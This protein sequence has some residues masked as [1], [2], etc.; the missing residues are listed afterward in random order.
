MGAR[1]RLLIAAVTGLAASAVILTSGRL[2]LA[3][4]VLI[5]LG[6]VAGTL[7][8]MAL[9]GP[10]RGGIVA[11]ILMATLNRYPAELGASIKPEH[12]AAPLVGLALLPQAREL[13]GRLSRVDWLFLAWIGWSVI[14]GLVHAPDRADSTQLWAMLLLVAFPYF[15]IV[16]TTRTAGRLNFLLGAWFAIGLVSGLFGLATHLLYAAGVNLGIQ[17]NPVTADPTVPGPFRESNLFGSAMMMLTLT[18]F[19]LLILAPRWRKLAAVVAPVGFLALQVS[20]TR[21]AWIAFV[22]GG[23][24][25]AGGLAY[26]SGRTPFRFDQRALRPAALVGLAAV[27]GTLVIW[28]PLGGQG[29]PD[30]E[31]AARQATARA[32]VMAT[33]NATPTMPSLLQGTPTP[34]QVVTPT[35]APPDIVGR[36]SS[37]SDVS[38][39]SLR[40]RLEFAEQA[41]RD[42]RDQPILGK[43]IGSFGQTYTTTSYDRAWLSNIFVRVLHDGGVVGFA[44]FLLPLLLL[45]VDGLRLLDRCPEGP[46]RVALALGLAVLGMFVAFQATEGFQLAWYW[47]SLGLFAAALRLANGRRERLGG[48]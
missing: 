48:A 28:V 20:F 8:L 45:A 18:A 37:I 12:F 9:L 24:A 34:F 6:S 21:T 35:P 30:H 7:A 47:A 16:T 38:D 11:L 43:G 22:A 31:E 25:L 2:E 10:A 33:P 17:I 44:L 23:L 1:R 40:I 42:W 14:G 27:I 39:S 32:T 3:P 36:V 13:L 19:A 29:S 5:P 41:L 46:D 4:D 26:L 15:A